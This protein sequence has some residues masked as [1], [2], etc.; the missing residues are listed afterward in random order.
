MLEV[1]AGKSG[2]PDWC[3]EDLEDKKW[4]DWLSPS[5]WA[6]AELYARE[7]RPYKVRVLFTSE[8]SV[9]FSSV[10]RYYTWQKG[11]LPN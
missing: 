7:G 6:R 1:I 3:E 5:Q 4:N 9:T 2:F 8:I 11:I 10:F